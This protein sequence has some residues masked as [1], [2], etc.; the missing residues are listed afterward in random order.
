MKTKSS[1]QKWCNICI[2]TAFEITLYSKNRPR[3]LKQTTPIHLSVRI[4]ISLFST[5]GSLVFKD[6]SLETWIVPHANN[7]LCF[8]K[9][10]VKLTPVVGKGKHLL[11]IN[12]CSTHGQSRHPWARMFLR[13]CTTSYENISIK[14][15][16]FLNPVWNPEWLVLKVS[17]N[18]QLMQSYEILSVSVPF[19]KQAFHCFC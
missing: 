15:N 13:V 19:S 8:W 14:T 2:T 16:A 5:T 9:C 11:N 12:N 3:K 17:Q 6:V 1:L 18:K 4:D 10:P 7:D